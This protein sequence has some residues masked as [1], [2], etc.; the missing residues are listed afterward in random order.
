M[1]NISGVG[2]KWALD[3]AAPGVG[4]QS[5]GPATQT[6]FTEIFS[7]MLE[8]VSKAQQKSAENAVGLQMNNP[9]IS[10]EDVA[11]A[12][13]EASL[14]FQTVLQVRNKLLQAYSE[15]MNMPV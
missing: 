2:S 3:M 11:I 12:S 6:E 1:N 7:N 14:K 13:N 5:A 15:V 8:N 9:A 10:V 4:S